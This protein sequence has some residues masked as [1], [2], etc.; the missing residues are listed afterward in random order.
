[1]AASK[2]V[3]ARWLKYLHWTGYVTTIVV[4]AQLLFVFSLVAS[5]WWADRQRDAAQLERT[6]THVGALAERPSGEVSDWMLKLLAMLPKDANASD[7]IH[8]AIAPSLSAR[9]YAVGLTPT[10][11]RNGSVAVDY[12]MV[13]EDLCD[14][15]MPPKV[16][17]RAF[18]LPEP[19][20][21][22]F[23]KWFDA[24]TD[25]YQGSDE[26]WLDGTVVAFERKKTGKTTSGFGN[27]PSHH[28]VLAAR[29]H[30]LL[31][32]HLPGPDIPAEGNWRIPATE[33]CGP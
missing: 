3:R 2:P 1:M 6:R 12:V 15:R 5:D 9:S 27:I 8:I 19:D 17:R 21:R 23:E 33:D 16:E 32:P 30:T 29:L 31:K 26:G 22:A 7:S 13:T 28:G 11:L 10:A 25:S 20:N 14:A 18:T 4:T 24:V